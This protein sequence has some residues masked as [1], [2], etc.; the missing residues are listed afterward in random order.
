MAK[1]VTSIFLTFHLT[2]CFHL[3]HLTWPVC[4]FSDSL[5]YYHLH[6]GFPKS[7]STHLHVP[8]PIN[9]IFLASNNVTPLSVF[10]RVLGDTFNVG[11]AP[12]EAVRD[13]SL[14]IRFHSSFYRQR[15]TPNKE[16][17]PIESCT[18]KTRSVP[19][20]KFDLI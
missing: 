15:A 4:A 19:G 14:N 20:V 5:L 9:K 7:D 1:G 16:P 3:H 12:L 8:T 11:D 10:L 6:R 2:E 18:H 17:H 13:S